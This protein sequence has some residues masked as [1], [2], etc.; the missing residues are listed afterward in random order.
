MHLELDVRTRKIDEDILNLEKA[1]VEACDAL[2]D[3]LL[4]L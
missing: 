3:S 1:P 4:T 2:P